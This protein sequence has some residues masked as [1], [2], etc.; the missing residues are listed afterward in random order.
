[1]AVALSDLAGEYTHA[2]GFV[3]MGLKKNLTT[4]STTEADLD[5]SPDVCVG[6]VNVA[7]TRALPFLEIKGGNMDYEV[8]AVLVKGILGLSEGESRAGG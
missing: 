3:I 7:S 6:R 2:N 8:Q 4:L 1:M 5:L